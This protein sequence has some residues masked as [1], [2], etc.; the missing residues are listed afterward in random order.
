MPGFLSGVPFLFFFRCERI[1]FLLP[2]QCFCFADRLL[3]R[4]LSRLAECVWFCV[5]TF[6]NLHDIFL[7][8]RYA[9]EKQSKYGNDSGRRQG[10]DEDPISA[11][12]AGQRADG[13]PLERV[14]GFLLVF[15]S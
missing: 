5:L 11:P 2:R 1:E 9:D 13:R 12:H 3:K 15:C 7:S 8:K 4:L 6:S 14:P 10:D